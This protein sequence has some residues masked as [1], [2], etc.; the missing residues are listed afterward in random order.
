MRTVTVAD[1]RLIIA[2]EY[3]APLIN[4]VKGAPG[5]KYLKTPFK[6]WE[7]PATPWHAKKLW[8]AL[9]DCGF[10]WSDGAKALVKKNAELSVAAT[11]TTGRPTKGLFGYQTA[12]VE[13]A[14]KADG[15]ALIGD[16]M[17][18]G[19]TIVTLAFMNRHPDAF[20]CV[21]VTPASVVYKWEK[22]CDKWL[23][24]KR[25]VYIVEGY[26]GDIEPGH[27]VYIMSYNVMSERYEQLIHMDEWGLAVLDECVALKNYKA[28]RTRCARKLFGGR[29]R[30]VLG[31]DGTPFL[32]KPIEMFNTL[33]L[34]TPALWENVWEYGNRYCAGF[35]DPK[36]T[37]A[38]ATNIAELRGRLKGTMIRRTKDEVA[39]Q[40]PPLTRS[41]IPVKIDK[42]L[43]K[44]AME[45]KHKNA[46]AHL[47]RLRHVLGQSKV[48][49]AVDW[50]DDF[51]SQTDRKLVIFCHH[52]D[53][54]HTIAGR[55][56]GHGVLYITG[57]VSQKERASR[58][59]QF[60]NSPRW[61]I[62]IINEAGGVGIDLFAASDIL[63]VERLWVP[64]KEEQ[65]EA[66][67]HRHGQHSPV[68]AWY[69]YASGTMDERLAKLVESKRD[70]F[71]AVLNSQE[72]EVTIHKELI[73]E[74]TLD[75]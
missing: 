42:A 15:R 27:E 73:E 60:Q 72:V 47:E 1:D 23:D 71:K 56:A 41:F 49:G 21:I 69:M 35:N 30:Y 12:A 61:R 9:K 59:E 22:E 65:A 63:F 74:L 39:D 31:L 11:K 7:V 62:M 34:I 48:D 67:L 46:A 40:L 64:G 3:D 58:I 5:R 68:T 25:D 38:G 53:V 20:P 33:N 52:L 37:F 26:K 32:N 18:L 19:K 66:R 28:K 29:S 24:P 54:I 10:E 14:L 4:K 6:H 57:D 43:Y 75:K 17:G 70:T 55:L 16:D 45:E 13:F 51:M 50:A 8:D 36:G 2:F 44:K